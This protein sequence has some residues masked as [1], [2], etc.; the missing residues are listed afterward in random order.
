MCLLG[1]KSQLRGCFDRRESW[2]EEMKDKGSAV[3][4]WVK[5]QDNKA[6]LLTKCFKKGDYLE[7]L[8]YMTSGCDEL[9]TSASTRRAYFL[10]G[11]L[12]AYK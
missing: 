5:G 3:V 4:Q 7:K 11:L 6:D 12:S 2:V 9:G 1:V 8:W 10:R